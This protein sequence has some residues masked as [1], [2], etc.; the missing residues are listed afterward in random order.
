MNTEKP[1][2]EVDNRT[3]L[4][5]LVYGL[6]TGLLLHYVC[7]RISLPSEPFIYTAF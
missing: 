5:S 1:K 7:Y 3:L 2:P 6:L 4:K